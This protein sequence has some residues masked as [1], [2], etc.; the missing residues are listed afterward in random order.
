MY[1]LCN[2]QRMR[3]PPGPWR[4]LFMHF[5]PVFF[6][7]NAT[8]TLGI[9][10]L[11]EELETGKNMESWHTLIIWSARLANQALDWGKLW[12]WGKLYSV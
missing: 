6:T 2:V 5:W 11:A 10:R 1:N 4:K 9:V 8:S 12:V 7:K 3:L